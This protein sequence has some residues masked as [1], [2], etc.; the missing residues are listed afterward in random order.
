[1]AVPAVLRPSVHCLPFVCSGGSEAVAVW[2]DAL[3]HIVYLLSSS[4]WLHLTAALWF[5]RMHMILTDQVWGGL[6]FFEYFPSA[7]GAP[8]I[9]SLYSIVTSGYAENFF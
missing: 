6:I 4:A 7:V 3:H 1:M 2:K 5:I 9:I 8:T